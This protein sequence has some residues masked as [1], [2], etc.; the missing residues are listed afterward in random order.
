MKKIIYLMM[1]AVMMCGVLLGCSSK[2]ENTDNSQSA[3]STENTTPVANTPAPTANIPKTNTSS[4]GAVTKEMAYEGVNNYCHSKFDWSFA[5]ENPS[6][7]YV[8][9]GEETETEYQVVYHSYT[10][11]IITFYVDKLTGIAKMTEYVPAINVKSDAGTIDIHEY[12]D[13]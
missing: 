11:A 12:L 4:E 5:E 1:V 10:G 3:G 6:L 7:M 13:K 8:E 2:T 9:M